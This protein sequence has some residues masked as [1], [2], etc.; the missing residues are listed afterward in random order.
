MELNIHQKIVL[1]VKLL[2]SHLGDSGVTR[3]SAIS[4]ILIKWVF[5]GHNRIFRNKGLVHIFQAVT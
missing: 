2:T 5:D 3:I 4:V 1:K